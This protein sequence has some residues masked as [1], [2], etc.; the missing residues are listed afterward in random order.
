MVGGK[1][2]NIKENLLE[3]LIY[4]FFSGLIVIFF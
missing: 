3:N 1:C 4:R 2:D